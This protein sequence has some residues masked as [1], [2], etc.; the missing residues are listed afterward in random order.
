LAFQ[1][2]RGNWWKTWSTAVPPVSRNRAAFKVWQCFVQNPLRKTPNG[3]CK[4]CRG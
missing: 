3:L 1:I 4:S 2:L